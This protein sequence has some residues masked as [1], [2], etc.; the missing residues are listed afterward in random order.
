MKRLAPFAA[1]VALVGVAPACSLAPGDDAESSESDY[2]AVSAKPYEGTCTPGERI[3]AYFA[4]TDMP[5]HA[6]VEAMRSAQHSIRIA[7]Y[8]IN[9]PEI[10]TVLRERM[11]AGVKVTLLEDWAH[12]IDDEKDPSSVWA[13]LGQHPNLT[14]Y[15]SPVLRGGTPQ[16]HDKIIVVDGARVMFGSANWT[17]TGLVGNFENVMSVRDPDV[18]KKYEAELD[19]LTAFAKLSCET[20]ATPADACGSGKPAWSPEFE[21]LARDGAFQAAP[22]GPIDKSRA[23]CAPLVSD[24]YGLL[25]PGNQ[26]RFS[27]LA[28]FKGCFVD[29]A[30]GDKYASYLSRASELEFYVDGTQVKA[31][32]PVIEHVVLPSGKKFD[33]LR[34]KHQDH[35]AGPF[36]VYFSGED[37]VEWMMLRELRALEQ[38]PADSFAYLST[39]FV[40]NGRLVDEIV[41]LDKAG[42][43]TRVFFD[44]GRF[45][46]PNF[47]SQFYKLKDIGFTFGLGAQKLALQQNPDRTW[48]ISRTDERED[49]QSLA[50]SAVSVFDDDLSGNYGA[51][52][53]K[54]AILG[55]K[56]AQGTYH[57]V[58]VN[59]SANWSG[60]AMERNDEN[61][62]VVE[63]PF[64]ASLYL[65]EFISQEYVY[66]YAQNEQSQGLADDMAFVSARVPCFDAVT[67]HP[68]DKCTEPNGAQWKPAV[69]G[70][71]VMAVRNV[72]APLDGSRRVW[73]WVSNWQA[74][75][76]GPS[77]RA[78]ELFSAGTFEGKWVTS[79]PYAPGA[80]LRY[81]FLTA[82]A[83]VDPNRDLGAAG[84][85]WEYGGMDNDRRATLG[86]R[87]LMT[88]RSSNLSWGSP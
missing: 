59:G 49:E 51:D 1:L 19:E 21:R 39:N 10:A 8:N 81:K 35:Q 83:N 78:F 26:L 3:C 20:F 33:D 67:G 53:N 4:P 68:S 60:M 7:T 37:D 30:L 88:I 41:K 43:R 58:L 63:D 13:L 22:Q 11:D 38:N 79:I 31:D 69:G 40:T 50:N 87:P 34:F 25:L 42:A 62:A 70:A 74:S 77:G 44:R 57:V 17:F 46:D 55:H 85:E 65:R 52:H 48:N 45:W 71:L 6:V 86:S 76:G 66:R 28:A 82:P 72:P 14:K 5:V 23:G 61:L 12:A 73:A 2:A 47:H 64:A 27:D 56:D 75:E 32:P 80:E 24:S 29:P 15:M 16:M 36:R 9:I 54:F 84:I 18:V